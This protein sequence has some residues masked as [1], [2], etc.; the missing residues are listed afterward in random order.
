ME[1]MKESQPIIH[2]RLPKR[3]KA[4]FE[5]ICDNLGMTVT[6]AI[7]MYVKAAIRTRGVQFLPLQEEYEVYKFDELP[8][9]TQNAVRAAKERRESKRTTGLFTTAAE[10]HAYI[11]AHEGD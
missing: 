8:E 10:M 6:G 2:I 1:A 5:T 11:S 7:Q 4:D 3:D 9:E